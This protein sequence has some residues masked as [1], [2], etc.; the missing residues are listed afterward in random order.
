M[1]AGPAQQG[2]GRAPRRLPVLERDLTVHDR[3]GNTLGLLNETARAAGQIGLHLRHRGTHAVFVEHE[4]VG[5]P[6]RAH[7]A[8]TLEL[9]RG[10]A[11]SPSRIAELL[12]PLAPDAA[13]VTVL[14]GHPATLS[15]LGGVHGHRI[16]PLGVDHFGQ[17]ADVGDLYRVHGID[18]DAIIDAVARA[19]LDRVR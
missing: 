6:A 8:A 2:A 9:P 19:C 4:Q 12:A 1:R 3:S 5:P 15:W 10:T 7:E 17:S 11:A 14:D 13:L 16:Y 18:G